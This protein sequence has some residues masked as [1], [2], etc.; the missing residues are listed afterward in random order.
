LALPHLRLHVGESGAR[1]F[2]AALDY[3]PPLAAIRVA[4]GNLIAG[5]SARPGASV[6]A[7]L[8]ALA[9]GAWLDRLTLHVDPLSI[10]CLVPD[11]CRVAGPF[12][13]PGRLLTSHSES[14]R[15]PMK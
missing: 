7:L 4:E 15:H 11:V 3:L 1:G 6:D 9:A 10:G 2:D 12:S 8:D 5:L 13:L 14:K